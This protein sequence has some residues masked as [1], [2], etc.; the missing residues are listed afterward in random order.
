MQGAGI[1]QGGDRKPRRSLVAGMLRLVDN[2]A[3]RRGPDLGVGECVLGSR[4]R[5]L[6]IVHRLLPQQHHLLKLSDGFPAGLGDSDVDFGFLYR[7]LGNGEILLGNHNLRAASLRHPLLGE[8]RIKLR[9]RRLL[10]P[11]RLFHAAA[12]HRLLLCQRHEAAA[13]GGRLLLVGAGDRHQGR[14]SIDVAGDFRLCKRQ[15]FLRL[16]A[17]SDG[18]L[19]RLFGHR[20][21]ERNLLADL[22]EAHLLPRQLGL[23]D[24]QLGLG[25]LQL[26]LK[27]GRIDAGDHLTSGDLV[28]LFNRKAHQPA[29]HQ[30]WRDVDERPLDERVVGQ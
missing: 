20:D 17:L 11:D 13:V 22:G 10:G 6:R 16:L 30:L 14:R 18:H 25:H 9:L 5:H 19:L 29:G 4:H 15:A 28:V 8:G 2:D 24:G 1:E 23:G 27:G 7:R 26:I 12:G 21:R 3:G